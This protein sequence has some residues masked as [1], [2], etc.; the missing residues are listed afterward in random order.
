MS[1]E[2]PTDELLFSVRDGVAYL[3][4]NRPDKLNACTT[5]MYAGIS[6]VADEVGEN[7]EIKVLV[8]TGA[9]RGF[10]AGSDAQDRLAVRA[11][12]KTLEQSRKDLIRP[13]GHVG[14]ALYGL[15]KPTI[16]AINGVCVGAGLSF[17]LLCDIRIASEKARFGAVWAKRGL[18][19]DVGATYLL[20]RTIGLD[21]ALK[22]CFTGDLID[23]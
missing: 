3:T 19:P 2:N 22:L 21:K 7:D 20:P 4:L 16:A 8:I 17:A 18:V 5:A 15:E 9:G 14:S 10:C 1:I 11:N 13:V 6:Q 12:G 23:S